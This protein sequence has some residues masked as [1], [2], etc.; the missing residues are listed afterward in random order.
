MASKASLQRL[1]AE[2][3]RE[4]NLKNSEPFDPGRWSQ[5]YGVPILSLGEIPA[6]PEARDR[7]ARDA[8]GKWSAATI[9]DGSGHVVIY[10]HSHAPVRV[11]SNLAHEVAHL[12][13]EHELSAAWIDSDG[14]CKG[15]SIAQERD[16]AELAGALLV[17]MEQ[18]RYLAMRGADPGAV[19]AQYNVSLK[20]ATWRL[21]ASGGRRIAER[22]R[23]RRAAAT[24]P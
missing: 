7:F 14:R 6:S 9:R 13:A 15:S 2:V 22:A 17:P 24:L 4:I 20:M 23:A 11:L 1:A 18:A 16:A 21:D 19:A 3:R 12:I 5:E 10:N 8:P